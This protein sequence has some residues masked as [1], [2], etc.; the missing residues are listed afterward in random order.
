MTNYDKLIN[1]LK[2]VFMLDKAEL[3]FGIYRIMNQKRKD[4]EQFLEV[5][6]VPQVHKVLSESLSVDKQALQKELDDAIKS[7]QALGAD[8]NTLPKVQDLKKRLGE[9]ADM[10][11]I[12]NEVFSLL[13]NFFKRYF[14][15]GDF[16]SMRRYK[17][18]VYAIPYEG[19]EVKLHWANADQYYIKTSEYF[20][21]Y[22]F[23]L[24]NGKTV[25]FELIEAS[26][27]QNNNKTQGDK[28]RRFAIY[29]EKVCETIGDEFKI[30]FTYEPAD[31]KVTQKDLLE[32]AFDA[33]KTQIPQDF[34][35]LLSLRPTEKDKQR[36]LLQKHLLDYTARN[37]FD[38]FIHKDLGGFLTR[39][40]DFYIKNEVLFIDDLNTRD[41]Q[42]FLKQLSKIKAIK[43]IG[44]KIITFLA[45]LENFQKKLWLKKKMVVECNY[46]IT[47]DRVPKDL[48]AEILN[49]QA[50]I[51]EWIKLYAIDEIKAQAAGGLF[52]E[53]RLGFSNPLT[54]DFLNQNQ[55]LVLD[56]AFFSET[57]KWKLIGSIEKFDKQC[58]GLL[59]NADNFHALGLINKRYE[60][61]IDG[62]YIDPPYNTDA[63]SILYKNDYKD[64]SFLSMMENR[65]SISTDILSNQGIICVAIDD[66]EVS[67]LRSILDR[68]FFSELGIVAVRSNPAGRKTKGRFAPAHEYALFFGNSEISSPGSL[69]LT[70]QRLA[71]Y[72]KEDENGRFAWA[73][74]IRSGNND[75]R[76]DRPKL[77]Y[78][79]FANATE[80]KIRIPE[81]VW[82]NEIG[83]YDLLENP[84][85]GEVVVYPIIKQ[86]ERMIEKNWQRG[87]IRVP[88][89]L[90]EYRVRQTGEGE[91]SVDFKTRLDE[92]SL[93]TTWWDKKEY[94]SANYGASELKELFNEKPFDFPKAKALV[95]DCIKA[96][97]INS[98]STVLDFF[99]GSATTGHA[100]IN[101]NR[102]DQGNRKFILV[103]MGE[104]FNIVTKPRIQKVVYSKDWKDGKP[105]SREGI[106]HC[107]KYMR[108]ESYEDTLNNLAL[109]QTKTQELALE[110][111]PTF[112]EGYMLNYMLDVEAKES[113]L[114]LEWFVN[115]F[116]CY[117]NITKNNELQPTKVDLVETF[118]YLIGLVVENYAVPK[119]GYLVVTGKNLAGEN[120]LVVWRD[121]TQHN[122]TALN[123]FLE[124]SKYN[125][126]DS[127]YDRIYVN[128]DNN[129]ENL[130]TGDERW[131]VVLIEEEF[132]KRMFE[133]I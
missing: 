46:C 20:K 124:K 131:K 48:Y 54:L 101:L 23:K 18:D 63:S 55:F 1:T 57:F 4:I 130:K 60:D 13:A 133:N 96:L 91:V 102:E 44:E 115:P 120:I 108:L 73:N 5:D 49:N 2:E 78:P 19:E 37:T 118:N 64:S 45:Q 28:E 103:E 71:R 89:E 24:A 68:L 33:V 75:K 125:P 69:D 21:V 10:V 61:E 74:F 3:D 56:T 123:Q 98:N 8:P 70:E 82:N 58:D 12:E 15:N 42:E 86:G 76:E 94:A 116:N 35:D 66:E 97:N 129:V 112:K 36:S 107:F 99:G 83:G 126:L 30:Y 81:I 111:N 85:E 109:K 51:Q 79:I 9:A 27:E 14:D 132:G 6:L 106:S 93:P 104:Y 41:E 25:A 72:P 34:T 84:L 80:N 100:I 22:R 67:P 110:M 38:Y 32:Q 11:G 7:A 50:Q 39:E 62:V 77:F 16:I 59:I 122:S 43:K 121:C 117:L 53:N 128:G 114:N 65:L 47:L 26:T 90:N 40:L 127:E 92:S 52:P 31:K 105:L 95:E 87:Y 119:E 17:K 113:L 29:T 88:N